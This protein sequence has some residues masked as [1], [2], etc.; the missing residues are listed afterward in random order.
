[1]KQ[2]KK[3]RTWKYPM[4]TSNVK[5]IQQTLSINKILNWFEVIE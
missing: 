5:F 1:M 3:R 4:D 2:L